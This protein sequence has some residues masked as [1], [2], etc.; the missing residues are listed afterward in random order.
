MTT[1]SQTGKRV[2]ITG[3]GAHNYEPAKEYGDLHIILSGAVDLSD[4]DA[5]Y[6][7][8]KS[9]LQNSD[10]KDYILMSGAPIISVLCVL[11]MLRKHNECHV[12]QWDGVLREYISHTLGKP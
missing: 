11:L 7:K 6:E 5:M 1:R 8:I 10:P 4:F 9:A 12:L 2:F 3:L